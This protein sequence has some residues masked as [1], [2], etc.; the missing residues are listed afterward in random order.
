MNINTH[1]LRLALLAGLVP[2]LAG[3][4]QAGSNLLS[5]QRGVLCDTY[6]CAGKDEGVSEALTRK[7]LGEAAARQLMAQGAFDKTVF[8]FT[9]GVFCDLATKRC[10]SNRYFD[11]QGNR[12]G[13]VR[14]TESR[15]LFG[16]TANVK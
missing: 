10:L 2:G 3:A 5:P 16:K 4:A 6:F 11:A 14:K 9:N 15:L 1:L 13:K 8:T 7:Y 12:S